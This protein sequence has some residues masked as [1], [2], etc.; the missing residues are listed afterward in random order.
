MHFIYVASGERFVKVGITTRPKAR[1]QAI[2][3]DF[4]KRGDAMARFSV[5]P[6]TPAGYG[7]ESS[8]CRDLAALAD[9]VHGRE[10]FLGLTYAEVESIVRP[11]VMGVRRFQIGNKQF[12]KLIGYKPRKPK[13][14]TEAATAPARGEAQEAAHG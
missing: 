3:S 5:M 7:V 11:R 12:Q 8:I 9:E 2:A 4:R 14:T 13:P 10:W 6:G 1:A